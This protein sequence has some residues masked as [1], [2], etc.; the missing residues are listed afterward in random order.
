MQ[1]PEAGV[2]E[3]LRRAGMSDFR[4]HDPRHDFGSRLAAKGAHPKTIQELMGHTTFEMTMRY[5]HFSSEQKQVAI[6]LLEEVT[7]DRKQAQK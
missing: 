5:T 7:T 3:A 6:A 4:L 1:L 2:K